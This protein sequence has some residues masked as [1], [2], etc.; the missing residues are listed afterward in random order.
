MW[1]YVARYNTAL[2]E[3]EKQ[4]VRRGWMDD[5]LAPGSMRKPIPSEAGRMLE[6][7]RTSSSGFS[8]VV[9]EHQSLQLSHIQLLLNPPYPSFAAGL[10]CHIPQ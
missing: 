2:W 8:V 3:A 9:T 6:W 4:D 10:L 7:D 1:L 5:S